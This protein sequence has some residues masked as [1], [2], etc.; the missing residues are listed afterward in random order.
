MK[1][2]SVGWLAVVA[3]APA[4]AQAPNPEVERHIAAARAVAGE[5][6]ALFE[7]ICPLPSAP[8]PIPATGGPRTPPPR[9]SWHA[10]LG[11]VDGYQYALL[12]EEWRAVR[13]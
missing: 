7:R 8:R 1:L 12:A 13:G 5:H 6:T 9:D 11:W 4:V 2:R 3:C 10:E